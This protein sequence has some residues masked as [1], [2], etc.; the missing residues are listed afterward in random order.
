MAEL[1]AGDSLL[2][3]SASGM[4]RNTVLGRIKIEQRPMLKISGTQSKGGH[5]NANT[6]HIFMQ[7]AETVRLLSDKTTALSDRNHTQ[8][9]RHGLVGSRRTACWLTGEGGD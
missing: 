1:K 7:Q 6:S 9:H 5:Q 3:V 8:H 4:T 2:A